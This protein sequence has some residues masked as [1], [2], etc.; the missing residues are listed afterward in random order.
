M[1]SKISWKHLRKEKSTQV[2]LHQGS[3]VSSGSCWLSMLLEAGFL[4][5]GCVTARLCCSSSVSAFL[6][7]KA[8]FEASWIFSQT[9][10]VPFLFAVC[11]CYIMKHSHAVKNRTSYK[12]EMNV[13]P[14][15][16]KT[17]LSSE[18]LWDQQGNLQ[19][20]LPF[21]KAELSLQCSSTLAGRNS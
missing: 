3:T 7:S 18:V 2:T 4:R 10:C 15:E 13:Q 17:L 14:H 5:Q 20:V 1:G 16:Q 12:R 8:E 21:A 6:L 11:A 19:C 9:K